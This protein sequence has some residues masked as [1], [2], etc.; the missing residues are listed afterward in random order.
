MY[1][2]FT[3]DYLLKLAKEEA[4]YIYRMVRGRDGE[5]SAKN[6]VISY[7][8]ILSVCNFRP[9][10][11]EYNFVKEAIPYFNLTE[12]NFRTLGNKLI[13]DYDVKMMLREY[14]KEQYLDVRFDHAMR[15]FAL[16]ICASDGDINASQRRFIT[17]FVP[18]PGI[19]E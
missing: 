9:S 10:T 4:D 17:D 14:R 15:L 8:A 16:G 1:E 18:L 19:A 11:A 2:G 6:F 7:A 3:Y 5:E 12:N 13:G